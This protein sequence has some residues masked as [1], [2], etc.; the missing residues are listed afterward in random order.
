MIVRTWSA[1]VSHENEA[2]Y[3]DSVKSRILPHFEQT[4]GYMGCHFMRQQ[5]E[6]GLRYLV[7][8]YWSSTESAYGLSDGDP[9]I[10]FI[11]EDIQAMLDQ[12]DKT[13]EY[14]E[15]AVEHGFK[16]QIGSQ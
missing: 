13:V 16:S 7:L 6:R 5:H 3:L 9:H 4:D 2:E 8:T 12:F 15:I 10:A 11:P 1:I 14:Y